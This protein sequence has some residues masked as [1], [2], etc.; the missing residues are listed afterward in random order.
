MTLSTN[1][2][3]WRSFI[4]VFFSVQIP[5]TCSSIQL[6]SLSKLK[7]EAEDEDEDEKKQY[8]DNYYLVYYYYLSY[9]IKKTNSSYFPEFKHLNIITKKN[10]FVLI[11]HI[12]HSS[13]LCSI[14]SLLLCS[15]LSHMK[16]PIPV[17]SWHTRHMHFPS[18]QEVLEIFLVSRC[19]GPC[20]PDLCG[21]ARPSPSN[22]LRCPYLYIEHA[23]RASSVRYGPT[24]SQYPPPTR[25]Q[26]QTF[27]WPGQESGHDGPVGIIRDNNMI[28]TRG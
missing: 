23:N 12:I 18:V 6:R 15:P 13:S 16:P 10:A 1:V 4:F 3:T 11:S 8:K 28:V 17:I 26:F 9:D 19:P 20:P 14:L 21:R 2:T 5:W 25:K 7:R 27:K 22:G 24:I